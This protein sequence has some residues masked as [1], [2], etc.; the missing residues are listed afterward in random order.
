VKWN[1]RTLCLLVLCLTCVPLFG[2]TWYV[3]S[4]GGTR[5]S[6]KVPNGQCDGKSDAAY[7]GSGTNKHCAFKD[8]RFL[9]QDGS[10]TTERN[11]FPGYGWIG[12]GGDTYLIRGSIGTGVSYRVGWSN[13]KQSHD[14]AMDRF[15]GVQGDP[16]GSGAPVPPSGT[17]E[18]HTRILG[19]N[20]ANCH[21]QKARTQLH[22]GFGVGVVLP[23]NGA[24]YV[25]VACLDITDFSSCGRSGQANGCNN[26]VGSLS[27]YAKNGIGWSNTSTHDTVTDVRI[28]GLAQAGMIGPTGDGV[29]MSY[30]DLLGN[31]SSG[32]NADAGDGSTG[33]GT[34]RVE[35]YTIGWNGCAEEYPIAHAQP[36]TDCTD[37]NGGG[38]GDGFGTASSTSKPA[39][40]VT[41]DQGNVFYNTQDGLD[42]LH[43][44]GAGSSMTVT[45]TL[46]YGNMGQQI[47]VGG[48][49]GTMISDQ[50]VTNCNAL[51]QAIPGTPAGYNTHLSDFCR[52]ADAGILLTVNNTVPLKFQSN[53]IYSASATGL[54]IE[55]DGSGDCGSKALIDYRDNIFVG[56]RNDKADGYPSGG[57]GDYSTPIY[58]G[59]EKNPFTNTG[60]VYTHN[61]T[62]HAKST[63]RCPARGETRAI[64]GDPHLVD[65]S[66]HVYGYGDMS[67]T[68]GAPMA[69]ETDGP[70]GEGIPDDAGHPLRR[71]VE[72]LSA[73]VLVGAVIVGMRNRRAD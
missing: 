65:E 72:V 30:V 66:W 52:A 13:N 70:S 14:D 18:Q 28:H 71:T 44:N 57:T 69:A 47:K 19:E 20:Y 61:V 53:T 3:R 59:T 46:A 45:H 43:I 27:D 51:R 31:A 62:F 22:G 56:F 25:D 7:P 29:V 12:A 34:L 9:W 35:H 55:C 33:T 15:M 37:D 4:D 32:W 6:T 54:E 49:A 8:V 23:L 50:V 11:A 10:Y 58:I 2:T 40:N 26:D 21:G 16:Y 24:S 73:G 68:P 5:F 1:C 36:Y 17:A 42:A 41:F 39:W 64:C 63:W 48:A 38:Y 67:R 60:S